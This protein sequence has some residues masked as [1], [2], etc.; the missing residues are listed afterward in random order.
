MTG[1]NSVNFSLTG[2][3]YTPDGVILKISAWVTYAGRQ[4]EKANSFGERLFL[5]VSGKNS[6]IFLAY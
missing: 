4:A 1:D 2:K 3:P 5:S 6:S